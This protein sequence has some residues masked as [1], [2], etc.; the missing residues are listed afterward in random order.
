MFNDFHTRDRL[1]MRSPRLWPC[2]PFLPLIRKRPDGGLDLGV[3]VDASFW[4]PRPNPCVVR[5]NLLLM[6]TDHE[7]LLALPIDEFP[8]LE[9]LLDAGW[10][11]D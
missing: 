5:A 7:E 10:R 1:M 3:M 4:Q 6:P 2:H 8:S 9:A 11:V